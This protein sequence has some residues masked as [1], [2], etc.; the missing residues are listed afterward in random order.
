[1]LL[2]CCLLA[3]FQAIVS[4]NNN[5]STRRN[6]TEFPRRNEDFKDEKARPEIHLEDNSTTRRKPI[7]RLWIKCHPQKSCAGRCTKDRQFQRDLIGKEHPDCFCDPFCDSVF[8]DCCADYDKECNASAMKTTLAQSRTGRALE[9]HQ[10]RQQ[11]VSHMDNR[12]VRT[13][14]EKQRNCEEMHETE[15][16][17]SFDAY[18]SNRQQQPNISQ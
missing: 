18:S 5:A 9:M 15:Q 17:G 1:M 16:R 3:C 7:P 6:E 11:P 14:L 12:D 10:D 8:N 4:L 13:W 2:F